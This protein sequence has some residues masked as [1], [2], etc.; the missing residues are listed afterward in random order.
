MVVMFDGNQT[1]CD[2]IANVFSCRFEISIQN[3]QNVDENVTIDVEVSGLQSC[4]V[5]RLPL[6]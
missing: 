1:T 2:N 3:I 5:R 6:V 4:T